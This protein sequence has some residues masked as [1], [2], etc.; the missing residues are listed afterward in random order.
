LQRNIPQ[1]ILQR[2]S[3]AIRN[4]LDN[5]EAKDI[6]YLTAESSSL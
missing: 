5:H 4:R 6:R 1:L 2:L 3:I